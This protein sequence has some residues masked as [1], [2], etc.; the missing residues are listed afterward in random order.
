MLRGMA[1]VFALVVAPV[2]TN[3]V[4]GSAQAAAGKHQL[5]AA[6]VRS[7][8]VGNTAETYG[9]YGAKTYINRYK[10][11]GTVEFRSPMGNDTGTYKITDD[12]QLCTSYPDRRNGAQVCLTI[13]QTGP[14][15]YESHSSTGQTYKATVVKG[16]Q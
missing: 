2:C 12:G 7:V 3:L 6:E 1:V 16:I 11:D 9:Q 4:Q 5:T 10:P 14:N 8:L 13:Y 15:E